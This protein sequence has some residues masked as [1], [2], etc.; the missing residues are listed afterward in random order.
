MIF[1]CKKPDYHIRVDLFAS[2]QSLSIFAGPDDCVED[3]GRGSCR[4]QEVRVGRGNSGEN[5][6][7]FKCV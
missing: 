5:L 4:D 2:I 6:P 1:S 3:Q 7:K